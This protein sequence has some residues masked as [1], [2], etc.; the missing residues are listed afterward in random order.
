MINRTRIK[1]QFRCRLEETFIAV[2]YC[3]A[4]ICSEMSRKGVAARIESLVE[5]PTF[6]AETKARQQRARGVDVISFGAGE[7][8]FETPERIKE[9]AV[10]AMRQGFTRYTAVEGIKELRSAVCFKLERDSGLAYTPEQVLVSCGSKQALFNAAMALLDPGDEAVIVSPYWVSYP[11]QVRLAGAVPMFVPA[12]PPQFEPC[13]KELSAAITSRSRVLI[14][15]SPNNPSGA[16]YSTETLQA[17]AELA[18]E[19]DLWIISDETYEAISYERRPTSIASL[20]SSVFNKTIVVNTCS[21]T[22]AMTGWRI[23]YAAGP[24]PLIRAMTTVQS[25]TTS[26][27]SS[28]SQWAAVEA[29][30]GPQDDV[31]E[32]VE[33]YR[34]RRHLMVTG[35]N[36]LPGVTC[37]QPKGGFYAFA[38]VSGLLGRQSPG[39]P[40]LSGS[41]DVADFFLESCHVVVIPGSAFGSDSHVRLSFA[42]DETLIKAGLERMAGAISLLT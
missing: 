9:A 17:I 41:N 18:V 25:Q 33:S 11:E 21:K 34:A 30:T 38:D 4:M 10:R 32:M 42:A 31:R 28:V 22:Y 15:N 12:E 26:N 6:A 16:V 35:L 19:R 5:S 8:D 1:I 7:P 40:P 24:R 2:L 13:P 36:D 3:G 23:G 37:L 27:P 20:G 29:L 39:R 14:L